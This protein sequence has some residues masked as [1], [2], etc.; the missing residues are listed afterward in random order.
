MPFVEADLNW[1]GDL[2]EQY[3]FEVR[4]NKKLS[5]LGIS[6]FE[7]CRYY[8]SWNYALTEV[9]R[10][11]MAVFSHK[12]SALG[13]S[14]AGPTGL[15]TFTNLGREGF[16]ISFLDEKMIAQGA[17]SQ[18]PAGAE[19]QPYGSD[20]WKKDVLFGFWDANDPL[21]GESY[22]LPEFATFL[23]SKKI[24]SLRVVHSFDQFCQWKP[25]ADPY[26]GWIVSL[27]SGGAFVALGSRFRLEDLVFGNPSVYRIPELDRLTLSENG[28]GLSDKFAE[29]IR[30]ALPTEFQ[31][32]KA[33]PTGVQAAWIPLFVPGCDANAFVDLGLR[34][35]LLDW[36]PA[37]F[38][39]ARPMDWN[40]HNPYSYLTA[41]GWANE[42]IRSTLVLRASLLE[43]LS[44]K[45][46]GLVEF[47]TTLRQLRGRVLTL[48]DGRTHPLSSRA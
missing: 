35:K 37:E 15:S 21:T 34:E 2:T 46:G 41:K 42:D 44:K 29:E 43:R 8:P 45:A 17:A 16:A 36:S 48:Q 13:V 32:P 39:V 47:F 14:G 19:S 3:S 5:E 10:G 18:A 33:V 11:L 1:T 23:S 31:H 38:L 20:K 6:G 40:I 24:F 22:L 25:A 26:M 12:R 7:S 28:T 4:L 27:G 30:A 9:I